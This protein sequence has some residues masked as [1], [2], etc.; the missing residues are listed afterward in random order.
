[1]RRTRVIADVMPQCLQVATFKPVQRCL[2][3]H[4][5]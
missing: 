5:G 3:G 1:L 2:F 4:D